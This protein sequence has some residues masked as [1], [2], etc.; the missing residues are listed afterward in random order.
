VC[1]NLSTIWYY[2]STF[3]FSQ[4]NDVSGDTI[5]FSAVS[6]NHKQCEDIENEEPP[7]LP[8]PR[9]ES[10]KRPHLTETQLN[11]TSNY[12]TQV[13]HHEQWEELIIV[14]WFLVPPVMTIVVSAH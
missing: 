11:P 10:L 9:G 14:A 8:P 12:G 13:L 5:E 6:M 7:P 1:L 2:F 3:D 4:Q